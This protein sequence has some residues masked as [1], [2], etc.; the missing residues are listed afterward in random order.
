M[1]KR[2]TA[3]RVHI[4]T[5]LSDSVKNKRAILFLG[6]GDSKEAKNAANQTPPDRTSCATSSPR[7]SSRNP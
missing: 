2:Q 7:A 6:A 4:P 5:L 3:A 1:P